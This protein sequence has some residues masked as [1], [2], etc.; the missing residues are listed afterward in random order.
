M[1]KSILFLISVLSW[2]C[3]TAQDSLFTAS[4]KPA[5]AE[6]D[7]ALTVGIVFKSKVEG[8]VTHVRIYKSNAADTGTYVVGVWS[9]TG[10]LLFSQNYKASGPVGWK[11][12]QLNE[13]VRIEPNVNY[14]ASV[15]L[16]MGKYG[17]RQ[18]MFTADRVRGNL[19]AP[20]TVNNRYTYGPALAYP[21]SVYRT[22]AYYVDIIFSPRKPLIV[23]AGKDSTYTLPHDTVFLKGLITGDGTFF[24]WDIVDSLSYGE[25]TDS[26][27]MHESKTLN[28]YITG[29][30]SGVYTYSLTGW[31]MYGSQSRHTVQ[32][33]MA[34]NPKDVIFEL[35]RDGTWR[36]VDDKKYF[37]L[38]TIGGGQQ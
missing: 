17:A 23:N 21:T 7:N 25:P 27:V 2:V 38:K 19:T 24:S 33:T 18:Y 15:Y 20:K 8:L 28:P 32:I 9:S 14:T 4:D 36:V 5:T 22:S 35:L 11:R 13:P 30:R 3:S 34:A 31:D 12:V 37:L 10:E 1:R 26:V 29:M 16:P 6:S